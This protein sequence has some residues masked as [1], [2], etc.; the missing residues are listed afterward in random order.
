MQDEVKQEQSV[1]DEV[2]VIRGVCVLVMLTNYK[3]LVS[4]SASWM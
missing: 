4:L 2:D 3:L 1:Q